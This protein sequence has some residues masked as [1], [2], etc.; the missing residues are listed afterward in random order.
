MTD[1]PIS[2][3]LSDPLYYLSNVHFIM[4]WVLTRYADC[5]HDE[6]LAQLN[7]FQHLP[8][9]TQALWVR[10]VMRK[11]LHFRQEKLNYPEI[12]DITAAVEPLL[13]AQWVTINAEVTWPELYRLLTKAEWQACFETQGAALGLTR[14]DSKQQ[15]YQTLTPDY[16]DQQSIWTQWWPEAPAPLLSLLQQ[17]LFERLKLMFFGNLHQDWSE[18]ILVELGYQ[19]HEKVNFTAEDRA[20]E[21]R[22]T[23]DHYW[24][25][26]QWREAL[27]QP[28]TSPSRLLQACLEQYPSPINNP[29][30][31]ERRSRLLWHMG[32][33]ADR[34]RDE[35]TALL[36]WSHSQYR[37]ARLRQ[38]RLMERQ[39][40]YQEAWSLLVEA[41]QSPRNPAEK[42]G[43][44]RIEKRLSQK[45]KQPIISAKNATSRPQIPT[46]TLQLPPTTS[47]E[48]AVAAVL[49][50]ESHPVYYTE[51]HLF[52]G[53]FGLLFWDIIFAPLPGAF[54]HPFQER[55]ADLYRA[56][57]VQRRQSAIHQRLE[58]LD[59]PSPLAT[60][61]PSQPRPDAWQQMIRDHWQAKQGITNP[62]VYWPLWRSSALLDWALECID[63]Q[64]LQVIFR[65][66]LS[67]LRLHRRGMPDLVQFSA[68]GELSHPV[69]GA[70][71]HYQLIEVKGPTDRLQDHQTRWI[72]RALTAGL[73]VSV[74][75]V[76]WLASNHPIAAQSEI[77]S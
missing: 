52:N 57:F 29:W 28:A 46:K 18:F 34:Q 26:H 8:E 32:L 75:H 67:D 72:E 13:K 35:A 6:E 76:Q 45:L 23:L 15:W 10:L 58:L 40:A 54:F 59:T 33:A 12:G 71:C 1:S 77:A 20:F 31:E 50:S 24:Q 43:L 64:T 39:G 7:T 4:D 51:N 38:L 49:G 36:A 70:P 41:L 19:T 21:D 73:P 16:A 66:L 5:L 3:S 74:V 47:V 37:E 48:Q 44:E 63:A 53:L 14:R 27:E 2:T 22:A 62:F 56:D 11:G 42:L 25:L 69:T 30:L 9:A 17:D 68:Q 55:P 60:H 61:S 65:D